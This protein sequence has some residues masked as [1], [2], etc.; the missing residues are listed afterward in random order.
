MILDSQ[1]GKVKQKRLGFTKE[2]FMIFGCG[3]FVVLKK[4]LCA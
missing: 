4:C 1:G 2:D 3:N